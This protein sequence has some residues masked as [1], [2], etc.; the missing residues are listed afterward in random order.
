MEQIANQQQHQRRVWLHHEFRSLLTKYEIGYDE[1]Y[2]G[3][4]NPTPL[5][6]L[7]KYS[8][9]G[10]LGCGFAFTQG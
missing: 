10:A 6:G 4:E 1:R 3:D 5:S 7:Q 2:F 9:N 8:G